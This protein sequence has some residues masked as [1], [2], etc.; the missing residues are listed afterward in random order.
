MR[1]PWGIVLLLCLGMCANFFD[2]GNLGVAAPVMSRELGLDK[3]QT[4][5]L[6]SAFFWTYSIAL[7]GAGWLVDRV[8]AR[9]VYAT[10]F[11]VWTAATL[12]TGFAGGFVQILILRM[13]LGIGES[14][15]Y[16][17]NSRILA[18]AF[19]ERRR[20]LANAVT[21]L[22][23]RVGPLLGTLCGALIVGRF[24]WRPLF[25]ITGAVGGLWLIPWL[26]F[27]PKGILKK[28]QGAAQVGYRELLARREVW[29]TFGGLFGANYAW[30]FVLSWLPSY[31]V[32]E[33]KLTMGS[34]AIWG[35]LPYLFMAV[36]SVAGGYLADR[37][38]AGA[39][40]RSRCGEP[41]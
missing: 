24:G 40:R 27:A 7:I 3:F 39:A 21:D 32:Q 12:F 5:I 10:G 17:T 31:L 13:M 20:G 22:G 18:T 14:V 1:N 38:I 37:W 25:L 15:T 30:Y 33:R 26:V 23:G 16:P 19:D 6:L 35:A 9:W 28:T 4:G 34:V 41:L 29:G 11:L 36:S 8:E 2:R